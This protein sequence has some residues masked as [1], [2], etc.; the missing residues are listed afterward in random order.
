MANSPKTLPEGL[1]EGLPDFLPDFLPESRS[2]SFESHPMG[3]F[4]NSQSAE[5]SADFWK[6]SGR[7]SVT[8]L[9]DVAH[10]KTRLPD[11]FQRNF[12]HNVTNRQIRLMK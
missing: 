12:C 5:I 9:G 1:P 2:G 7:T 4:Q 6:T 3:D 8:V 11:Y 10:Q